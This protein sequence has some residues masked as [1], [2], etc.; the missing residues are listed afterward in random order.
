M[1]TWRKRLFI[2]AIIVQLVLAIVF[3][4]TIFGGIFVL[5]FIQSFGVMLFNKY[6]CSD[7]AKTFAEEGKHVK[8][9]RD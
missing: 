9:W 5:T 7:L 2:I 4:G 3:W 8:G 6:A 1:P